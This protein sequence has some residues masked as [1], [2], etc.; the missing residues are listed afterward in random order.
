MHSVDSR[1]E[2]KF[3]LINRAEIWDPRIDIDPPRIFTVD[4]GPFDSDPRLFERRNCGLSVG[5]KAAAV[6]ANSL[7]GYVLNSLKTKKQADIF[8]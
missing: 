8:N 7:R 3:S 1:G 6:R 4:A 5:F 2:A